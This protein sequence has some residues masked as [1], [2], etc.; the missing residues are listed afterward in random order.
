MVPFGAPEFS[1]EN[2]VFL[3]VTQGEIAQVRH[4]LS[5]K[6]NLVICRF[7]ISFQHDLLV[8]VGVDKNNFSALFI[9]VSWIFAF[10]SRISNPEETI[11][12]VSFHWIVIICAF[13]HNNS[14]NHEIKGVWER[15]CLVKFLS[16]FHLFINEVDWQLGEH[17]H[18]KFVKKGKWHL[19]IVQVHVV[20]DYFCCLHLAFLRS[21]QQLKRYHA[22]FLDC[23]AHLDVSFEFFIFIFGAL[24]FILG[25]TWNDLIW[26]LRLISYNLT[27]SA[28][29]RVFRQILHRDL[30]TTSWFFVSLVWSGAIYPQ[31]IL[32][33]CF[34]C[35]EIMIIN[36]Y[37]TRV[38]RYKT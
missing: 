21:V 25:V 32:P 16:L 6:F 31:K 7:Q 34:F 37:H 13:Y 18:G 27:L 36:Y 17:R 38:T 8:K 20:S 29:H 5:Q 23:L 28:H 19:L 22:I 35:L 2:F 33:S 9:C 3:N 14:F 1:K 26:T 15:A 11:F 24:E 30:H 12:G 10:S 4:I